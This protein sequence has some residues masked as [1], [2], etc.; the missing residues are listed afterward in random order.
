MR[1]RANIIF[2][3]INQNKE[4]EARASVQGKG[5]DLA[6]QYSL[7]LMLAHGKASHLTSLSLSPPSSK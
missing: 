5:E 1:V 7:A 6:A 4:V 2:G 3:C